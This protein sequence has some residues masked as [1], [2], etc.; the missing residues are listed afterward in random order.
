MV[1]TTLLAKG[2][3]VSRVHGDVRGAVGEPVRGGRATAGVP[4]TRVPAG[5]GPAAVIS[6]LIGELVPQ[7]I[8]LVLEHRGVLLGL[9]DP[10]LLQGVGSRLLGS[11][12]SLLRADLV[13]CRTTSGSQVDLRASSTEDELLALLNGDSPT[14]DAGGPSEQY[15]YDDGR[16]AGSAEL[17]VACGGDDAAV[18]ILQ[19]FTAVDVHDGDVLDEGDGGSGQDP[20]ELTTEVGGTV[21]VGLPENASVGDAWEVLSGYGEITETRT[22]TVTVG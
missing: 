12:L 6:L 8:E 16:Y 13:T 18:Q 17:W 22:A 4:A 20:L 10:L 1:S 5:A 2:Q 19:T 15:D 21:Y 9:A 7:R 3:L 14:A 11:L